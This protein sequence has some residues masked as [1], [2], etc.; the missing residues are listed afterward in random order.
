MKTAETQQDNCEHQWREMHHFGDSET[1]GVLLHYC[2]TGFK[3][4]GKCGKCDVMSDDEKP[5]CFKWGK[6]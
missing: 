3:Q 5:K 1:P 2:P 4:C 6:P